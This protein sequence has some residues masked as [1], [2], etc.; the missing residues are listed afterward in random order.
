MINVMNYINNFRCL[1]FIGFG[2]ALNYSVSFGS[3]VIV[4]LCIRTPALK[5]YDYHLS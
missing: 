3:G 4:R 5:E 2:K 1:Y